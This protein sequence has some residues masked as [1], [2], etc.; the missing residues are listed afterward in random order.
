LL[1]EA[2]TDDNLPPT[3]WERVSVTDKASAQEAVEGLKEVAGKYRVRPG[4]A[5]EQA[6]ALFFVDAGGGVQPVDTF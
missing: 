3:E 6:F 5:P 4:A 2:A 1:V